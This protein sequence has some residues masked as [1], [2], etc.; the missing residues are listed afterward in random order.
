[1][2]SDSYLRA[3]QGTT[4]GSGGLNMEEFSRALKLRDMPKVQQLGYKHVVGQACR[5]T[6]KRMIDLP[7]SSTSTE[8]SVHTYKTVF[9]H[10][11]V[12]YHFPK[13]ILLEFERKTANRSLGI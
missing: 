8:R 3:I 10:F 12:Q 6:D 1:M 5:R 4:V 13:I 9:V 2:K 7:M 11:H